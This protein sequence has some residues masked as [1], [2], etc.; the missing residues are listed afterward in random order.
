MR[1]CIIILFGLLIITSNIYSA[2]TTEAKPET[3]TEKP[4]SEIQAVNLVSS[5]QHSNNI[6]DLSQ[7]T[8][9]AEDVIEIIVRRHPEFSDKYTV[10]KEGKIQ[11]KFV[12]DIS[13]LGF[14]KAGLEKQL[15]KVLSEYIV[16]PDINV[17]ILEYKSKVFYVIGEVGRPGEYYMRG[18]SVTVREA[19]IEAGLPTMS[20]AMRKCRLIRPDISGKPAK[21]KVDIY[22]VLYGGDLKKNIDMRPG[23]VLYVPATVMA[24]VMRVIAPV[25][26]P[27]STAASTGRAVVAPIP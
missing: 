23:D 26:A 3:V 12:G 5:A 13:V 9:G 15:T 19:V 2:G 17:T 11:Y 24:K 18:N 22:S 1:Y 4:I 21:I 7:Y 27:I 8:L 10:N 6:V 14:T 20:A 16:E 25:S